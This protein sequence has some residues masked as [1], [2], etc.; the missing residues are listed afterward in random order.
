MG[1]KRDWKKP[2]RKF[3]KKVLWEFRSLLQGYGRDARE[4]LLDALR[5]KKKVIQSARS[6][7]F[8]EAVERN[9]VSIV[10]PEHTKP[11]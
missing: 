11:D 2:L 6:T 4:A 10:Y 7:A 8:I 9:E 1:P 3:E 5:E